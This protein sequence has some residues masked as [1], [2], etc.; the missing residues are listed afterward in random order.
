MRGGERQCR[1]S[2]LSAQGN[3]LGLQ[4]ISVGLSQ[5]LSTGICGALLILS[6]VDNLTIRIQAV[7]GSFFLL[8][9][10][11]RHPRSLNLPKSG[12]EGAR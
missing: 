5:I 10:L 11:T 8:S 7:L 12:E 1:R 6:K 3:T 9:I 2:V 4:R